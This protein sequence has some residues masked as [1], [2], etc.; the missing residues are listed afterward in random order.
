MDTLNLENFDPTKAELQK[1][2]DECKQITITDFEDKKQIGIVCE[3]REL[4]QRT[5]I[6]IQKK[7]KA[8]REDAL[9]YQKAVIAKEKELIEIIEPEE[10]RLE[11]LEEQAEKY[12]ILQERIRKLPERRARLAQ[13]LVGYDLKDEDINAMDDVIFE[14]T[15][16]TLVSQRIAAENAKKEAE[17][18]AKQAEIEAKEKQLKDKELAMQREEQAK[19]LAAQ[20]EKER[21]DAIEQARLD[22]ERKAREE[23]A[24][25]E[26]AEKART[27]RKAEEAKKEAEKLEKTKKFKAFLESNGCTEATRGDFKIIESENSLI[28]YKRVAEF[29]K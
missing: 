17:L 26:A 1:I 2:A 14:S 5:R 22:G 9:R 29:N 28:L 20:Q 19:K 10:E 4:L 8:L 18:N 21:Q 13:E 7:G 16:N 24:L 23:Q 6:Q 11:Q 25:K 3:K 27:A 12:A 15:L